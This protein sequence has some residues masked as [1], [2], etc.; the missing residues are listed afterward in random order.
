MPLMRSVRTVDRGLAAPLGHESAG[1]GANDPKRPT[2]ESK[3]LFYWSGP[4]WQAA[5]DETRRLMGDGLSIREAAAAV[6]WDE[7]E[8]K[9]ALERN[10]QPPAPELDA[11]KLRERPRRTVKQR[12]AGLHDIGEKLMRRAR[13]HY[14][15]EFMTV[16]EV[17]RAIDEPYEKTYLILIKAGTKFRRPGRRKVREPSAS[18]A[19]VE[20]E[21]IERQVVREPEPDEEPPEQKRSRAR[22]RAESAEVDR[23]LRRVLGS[24]PGEDGRREARTAKR[25]R[26]PRA[27]MSDADRA[28]RRVLNGL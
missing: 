11:P 18:L 2:V 16:R 20:L 10:G 23:A 21:S 24:I 5:F 13:R 3:R 8:L 9:D 6:G 12:V 25:P 27:Q 4:G 1:R 17:S 28:L 15:I 26:K 14:E 7:Q 19:D 22:P